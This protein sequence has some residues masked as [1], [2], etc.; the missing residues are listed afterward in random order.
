MMTA[1]NDEIFV[2][3]NVVN[4]RTGKLYCV[5]G[6]RTGTIWMRRIGTF[7][8]N[9]GPYIAFNTFKHRKADYGRKYNNS[10]GCTG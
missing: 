1:M 5:T 6:T 4:E 9:V 8:D 2:G 7:G 10:D 3:D